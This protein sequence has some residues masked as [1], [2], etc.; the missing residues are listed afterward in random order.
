MD[1]DTLIVGARNDSSSTTL[2]VKDATQPGEV[3]RAVS[4]TGGTG[5]RGSSLAGTGVSGTSHTG[6]GVVGATRLTE[7]EGGSPA[8]TP[9]CGVYGVAGPGDWSKAIGII[10]YAPQGAG[11]N[12]TSDDGIGLLASGGTAGVYATAN[13]GGIPLRAVG[14][15]YFAAWFE[16]DV[17]MWDGCGINGDLTVFGAKSAAVPCPDGSLRRLYSMESPESW[18]EDFGAAR[19]VK[20]RATVRLAR[21]FAAV[22][23]TTGYY[24]FLTPEGDSRGLYVSRKSRGAFEVR[25]QQGGKSTLRFSYRIVA[26]RKDIPGRRLE[27]V[28]R[29]DPTAFPRP[30]STTARKRKR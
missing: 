20:G 24:V 25:E 22:V 8:P 3:L 29:P 6:T 2:L 27:K 10:G 16:G 7:V 21:D 12:A 11:V 30:A 1:G 15:P 13:P 23:R 19:V 5:V 9:S 26:K 18:F 14:R 28:T 4:A 17:Q